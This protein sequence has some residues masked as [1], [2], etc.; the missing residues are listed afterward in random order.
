MKDS[1]R[2]CTIAIYGPDVDNKKA[3][4]LNKLHENN[5]DSIIQVFDG[6]FGEEKEHVLLSSD[7][8]LL[9]SRFEGHPMSLIEAM[10]Y[11]LPCIVTEGSNMSLEIEKSDSGWACETSSA[12]IQQAILCAIKEKCSFEQKGINA[13]KVAVR[14][15]WDIIAKESHNH[16]ASILGN[17]S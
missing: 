6:V 5:L 13:R 11:G 3:S 4:I 2:N 17:E 9:P 16:L 7:V 8:F 14:Y 15:S 12:A 1:V 10:A